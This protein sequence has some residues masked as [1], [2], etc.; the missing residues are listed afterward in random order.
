MQ[1]KFT[2]NKNEVS[3]LIHGQPI[4]LEYETEG[5]LFIIILYNNGGSFFKRISFQKSKGV[6]LTVTNVYSPILKIWGVGWGVK[7]IFQFKFKINFFNTLTQL[8]R[9]HTPQLAQP[10]SM[11]VKRVYPFFTPSK[12]QLEVSQP[13]LINNQFIIHSNDDIL[14]SNY[15]GRRFKKT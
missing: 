15:K 11:K 1:G 10:P 13:Y 6:F 4:S 8:V 5:C 14:P 7:K 9:T 12:I 2:I 3:Y